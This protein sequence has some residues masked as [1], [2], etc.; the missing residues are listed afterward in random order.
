MGARCLGNEAFC[1][2]PG[3]IMELD[4]VRGAGEDAHRAV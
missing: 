4:A 2:Q 3:K 1:I